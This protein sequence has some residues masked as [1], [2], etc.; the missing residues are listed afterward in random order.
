MSTDVAS[1]WLVFDLPPGHRIPRWK[2]LACVQDGEVYLPAACLGDETKAL[3]LLSWD[4]H[5]C[6]LRDGHVYVPVA[7]LQ[8]EY[9]DAAERL[10][11]IRRRLVRKV[12]EEERAS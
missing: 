7:W 6:I 10:A 8:R 12:E 9:P 2:L 3:Y 11:G 5:G 1:R 4:G